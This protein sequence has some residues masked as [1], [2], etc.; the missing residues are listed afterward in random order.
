MGRFEIATV[1]VGAGRVGIC[2][3]P[4]G[5]GNYLGD[6][7]AVLAWRPALVMTMVTVEE[8]MR[9]GAAGLPSDLALRDIGWR[10]L[11]VEDFAAE[12]AEL[13]ARWD[14]ASAEAH[15][16]LEAGGGVLVHCRGGCGRSGMAAL[17]LM[18]EAGEA[19][20][21]ALARLREVRPCAVETG[22]QK[23]WAFAGAQS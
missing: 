9:A 1:P 14:G 4:G 5:A 7:T 15:G 17:R 13:V 10:H 6:L 19:P 8:L 2:P 11:P 23:A 21:P 20:E 3:V 12:S 18:V 16:T 22:E